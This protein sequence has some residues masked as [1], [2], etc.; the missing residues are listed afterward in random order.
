MPPP[1]TPEAAPLPPPAEEEKKAEV[2]TITTGVGIRFGMQMQDTRDPKKLG[3]LTVDELNG[4]ARFSGKV[5]D[6]VG[7]TLNFTVDGRTPTT[8]SPGPV[9][10]EAKAM[11]VVA[12]LD[13][14][15]EFHLWGGRMLTPSDR[16]NFS[17]PWFISPWDYPGL[18]FVGSQGFYVGPR[19]TEEIGREVGASVWGDIGKGKFKYYL[20][21]MDLD[22]AAD[23]IGADDMGNPIVLARGNTPLYSARVQYAILGEEPGF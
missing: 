5:L 16:T 19:G 4:E 6:F 22:N 23:S 17:G 10:F 13:F 9:A 20:A 2:F 1:S 21:M 18:Y 15:D 12:Q 14:V 11:D 8:G 3:A 7:W